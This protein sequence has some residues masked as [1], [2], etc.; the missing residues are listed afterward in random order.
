MA[1]RSKAPTYLAV[2]AASGVGYYLYNA[3]GNPSA[4]AKQAKST[5]RRLLPICIGLPMTSRDCPD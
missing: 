3:G 1:A 5:L 4:A 2:A